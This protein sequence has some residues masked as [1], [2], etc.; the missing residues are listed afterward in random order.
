[1]ESSEFKCRS[2]QKKK[3]KKRQASAKEFQQGQVWWYTYVIPVLGRQRE[4]N[5]KFEAS[6]G[7]IVRPG[8][9]KKIKSW[10]WE[11]RFTP[12]IPATREVEIRRIEKIKVQGRPRQKVI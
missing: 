9:K 8:L 4:E 3:K 10:Y 2:H 1:M 7:Y 6:L 11:Q 5:C 12:V